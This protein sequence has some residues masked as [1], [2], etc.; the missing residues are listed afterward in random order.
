M[1]LSACTQRRKQ[2][3]QAATLHASLRPKLR[4]TLEHRALAIRL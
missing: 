2:T 3:S 1:T 4:K